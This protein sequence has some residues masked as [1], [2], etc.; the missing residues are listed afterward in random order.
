[1]DVLMPH[2]DG[3][4]VM[5]QITSRTPSDTFFPFLM[6][7][8]DS[9]QETRQRA[10]EAGAAEFITKPFDHMEVITRVR[11]LLALRH[12][13]L[14][15]SE[16]LRRSRMHQE[17]LELEMVSRLTQVVR[18]AS[19]EESADA[20]RVG[21][22]AGL[23]ARSMGL[24]ELEVARIRM[25]APLHDIGM[26]G[27]N[28]EIVR[29]NGSLSLEELDE[30]RSHTALGAQ[31]LTNSD[32]PVMQLA[33]EIAL[34]HHE[35]WDGSGY[36]PGLGGTAVPLAARIVAVA[37]TYCA[38]TGSRPY[39]DTHTTASAV[40]WIESQSGTRFDPDVVVAFLRVSAM[41][42]LPLLSTPGPS[43]A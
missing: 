8:G 18:L 11:N 31:I 32:L 17:K 30:V 12:S 3:V 22:L 42:H 26:V 15:L 5:Q 34:Y 29:R 9:A 39:Q 6:I 21:E 41:S 38:M 35:A 27:V 33:E 10:L 20:D 37:D 1:M 14:A 13:Q 25:A 24:N 23:I 2:L 28:R 16:E 43:R 40:A 19:S 36:T 4:A 7:T